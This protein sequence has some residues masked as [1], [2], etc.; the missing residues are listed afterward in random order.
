VTSL[1]AAKRLQYAF[2]TT[3]V[4]MVYGFFRLLPLET[5]SNL[6]GGLMRR[7]GPHLG[8][9]KV[10]RRNLLLAFPEKSDAEREEIVRGMWDNLG[11][12]VAEYS[13][14]HRIFDHVEVVGAEKLDEAKADAKAPI[15]FAAHL[16]NWEINA[17]C[18]RAYGL[19]LH[20]VYRKPNNPGVDGLLRHARDSGAA[21]YIEKGASGARRILSLIRKK[22]AIGVLID[23]KLNDGIAVPFFGHDA[24][25][26]PAIAHFALQY[27]CPL[28]PSRVERVN[29]TRF[30][31]TVYPKLE[32]VPTGDREAD[33]LRV[34]TAVNAIMEDWIRAR[35][36]QW[37]WIHRRW[38]KD[39]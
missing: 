28:Y 12:V 11:R 19:P 7:I 18:A 24:M 2:E 35:P 29:G 20:L 36:E 22:E 33:V 34:M 37:L 14:L 3:V 1:G 4:Y 15:F 8:L 9:S 38:P 26:A 17:V 32:V 21:S 27:G 23:Q 10:A 6:G 30:V 25:T 16:A 5:A 13:H 31:T 39:A